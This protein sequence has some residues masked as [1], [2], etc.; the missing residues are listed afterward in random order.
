[1][2][3]VVTRPMPEVGMVVLRAAGHEAAVSPHDRALS[4]EELWALTAGAAGLV[5]MLTDRVDAGLLA[6][7]PGLRAVANFAVGFNNIDVAACTARGVG[8]ANTPEVLT[9]ATAEIAWSLLMAAARR[10]GEGERALRAKQW[11]GWGPL[12]YLGVDVVGKTLGVIGAGRIGARVAKMAAGFEMELLYNNRRANPEMERLGAKFVSLEELLRRADFVSVHV[13]LSNETRHLIGA[14]ELGMMKKTA[15]LVN[16]ARGPV[17]DEGALVE[18]LRERRI[19]AAGLD[20]FENE[21]VL[22]PGLYELE[23]VVILPHVG[24]ATVGTRDAM[25]RLVAENMAAM[26][27]GERPVGAVNP[28]VWG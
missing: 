4:A 7:R 10:T 14:R 12:Q 8:V 27:R 1:M 20:V 9:N 19:F 15:V 22:H 18:A 16:T 26:L 17:V 24:S 25:A 13:P 2:R 3:V 6:A 21:P 5:S 28:E 23:N 11:E